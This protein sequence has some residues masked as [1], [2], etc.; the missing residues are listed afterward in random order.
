MLSAPSISAATQMQEMPPKQSGRVAEQCLEGKSYSGGSTGEVDGKLVR[1]NWNV[2][3]SRK[4]L[5]NLFIDSQ[6][7]MYAAKARDRGCSKAKYSDVAVVRS[8]PN[9]TMFPQQRKALNCFLH[10]RWT[11]HIFIVKLCSQ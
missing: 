1:K 3:L 5:S 11:F 2:G 4:Q 10:C 9:W 7:F 8:D 6:M